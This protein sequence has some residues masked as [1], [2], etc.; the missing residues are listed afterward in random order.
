LSRRFRK[1]KNLAGAPRFEQGTPVLETGILPVKLH[2]LEILDFRFWILDWIRKIFKFYFPYP[3]ANRKSKIAN[4][5]SERRES[6]PQHPVWK[7]GTQPF[8][9]R[10][11]KN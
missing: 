2:A 4:V 5:E 11:R 10:S 8:E 1:L 3:I 7:T 6:N 9:F